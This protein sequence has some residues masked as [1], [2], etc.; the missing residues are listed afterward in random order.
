MFVIPLDGAYPDSAVPGL[1]GINGLDL[2]T[3]KNDGNDY[4]SGQDARLPNRRM[5]LRRHV[6]DTACGLS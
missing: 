2:L 5:S 4:D 3:A 1:I 6:P